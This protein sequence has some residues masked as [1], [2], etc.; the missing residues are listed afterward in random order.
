MIL[1]SACDWGKS[2]PLKV[3]KTARLMRRSGFSD[4]QIEQVV[5]HNP[6]AFF[7][8]GGRLDVA[9]LERPLE[10]QALFQGNSVERGPRA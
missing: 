8:Q 6:V 1:N 4:A 3:P 10:A 7:A 9:E 2:D 5:W